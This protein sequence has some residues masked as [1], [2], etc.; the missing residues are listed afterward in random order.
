MK[1]KQDN[2]NKQT[3][4]KIVNNSNWDQKTSTWDYLMKAFTGT[5]TG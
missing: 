1:K 4:S 5:Y 3:Q 2:K